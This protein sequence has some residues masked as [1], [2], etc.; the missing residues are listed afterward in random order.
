L[1]L[2]GG[3][4]DRELAMERPEV[5]CVA[6]GMALEVMKEMPL[7][8]HGERARHAGRDAAGGCRDDAIAEGTRAAKLIANSLRR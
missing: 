5:E 1:D 8:V 2:K 7:H 6:A 4:V 3:G